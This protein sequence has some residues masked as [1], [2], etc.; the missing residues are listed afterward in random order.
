MELKGR[1]LLHKKF[2]SGII[3]KSDDKY[4]WIN[5]DGKIRKFAFNSVFTGL[6]LGENEIIG[7]INSHVSELEHKNEAVRADRIYKPEEELEEARNNA[8]DENISKADSVFNIAVNAVYCNGGKTKECIGFNG[9][10]GDDVLE[11][12]VNAGDGRWCT[13]QDCRCS[14][15]MENKSRAARM[16]LDRLM[17]DDGFVCYESR[18][19]RDW[20]IVAG[21]DNNRG[22]RILNTCEGK[23]CVLTTL[24]NGCDEAQRYIF[25]MY[26]IESID[27]DINGISRLWAESYYKYAFTPDTARKMLFWSFADNGG[28][29]YWGEDKFICLD[30]KICQNILKK[31]V[32]LI[33]DGRLK[34]MLDYYMDLNGCSL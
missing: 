33:N 13:K 7:Y 4:I 9:V 27:E 17:E 30:N 3:E 26:I 29:P 11:V 1:E 24:E 5:F 14:I 31:S 8:T 32:E 18:M 15:Y 12:N 21:T 22:P 16:E 20:V 6:I 2:G 28:E 19:L 23:L 10:C 34:A 25:A